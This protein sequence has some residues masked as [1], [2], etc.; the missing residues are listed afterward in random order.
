VNL[1]QFLQIGT[2]MAQ[3][4]SPVIG[5]SII[6]LEIPIK[7]WFINFIKTVLSMTGIAYFILGQISSPPFPDPWQLLLYSLTVSIF[8]H[9]LDIRNP[10][11]TTKVLGVVLIVAHL[12]SQWWEIPMFIIVHLGLFGYGYGYLGSIDQLYLILVFYLALRLSNISIAKKD[13]M[14]LS[15]PI[16]FSTLAFCLN[17][18]MISY[19][20]PT[21]FFARCLSCFCLGKFFLERSVL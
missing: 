1:S 18:I 14:L 11:K 13:L 5:L 12:F 21:W 6:L 2:F 15:A 8:L 4:L 7:K 10:D 3:G 20:T 16:I 19:V 17:P 9:F